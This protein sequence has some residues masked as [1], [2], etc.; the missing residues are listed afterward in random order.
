MRELNKDT[1]ASGLTEEEKAVMLRAVKVFENLND[2]TSNEINDA[3]YRANTNKNAVHLLLLLC[4]DAE[5]KEYIAVLRENTWAMA[6][7]TR[8]CNDVLKKMGSENRSF[9]VG[10]LFGHAAVTWELIGVLSE[11]VRE[12]KNEVRELRASSQPEEGTTE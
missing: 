5:Y 8:S 1:Y 12:L 7:L 4:S 9:N 3:C 6:V 10:G 11:Q 2:P